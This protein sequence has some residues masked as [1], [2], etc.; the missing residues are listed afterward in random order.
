[1]DNSTHTRPQ[2]GDMVHRTFDR[3][4]RQVWNGGQG[5]GRPTMWCLPALEPIN[6]TPR[7]AAIGDRG[8]AGRK[9]R[10]RIRRP[11]RGLRR[12]AMG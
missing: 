12:E 3:T 5:T 6:A 9:D 10:P 7:G 11:A 8:E 2:K 4:A 1:M